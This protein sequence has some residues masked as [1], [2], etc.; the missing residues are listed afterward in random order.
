MYTNH[1]PDVANCKGPAADR[2]LVN[3]WHFGAFPENGH[4]GANGV[5]LEAR[6]ADDGSS[7]SFLTALSQI[8]C[9]LAC[10]LS[11]IRVKGGRKFGGAKPLLSGPVIFPSSELPGEFTPSLE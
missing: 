2:A 7:L 4:D 9:P 10:P 11:R 3:H 8:L 6:P 1:G 5:L